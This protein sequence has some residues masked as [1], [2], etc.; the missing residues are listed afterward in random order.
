MERIILQNLTTKYFENKIH[1]RKNYLES[2]NKLF[3]E[4]IYDVENY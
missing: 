2:F 1:D 4:Q 3:E